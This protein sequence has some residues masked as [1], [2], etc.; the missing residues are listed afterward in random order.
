[1][2]QSRCQLDEACEELIRDRHF[3]S[4]LFRKLASV[5]PEG[6]RELGDAVARYVRRVAS[7]AG[8]PTQDWEDLA[9]EVCAR[10]AS[11]VGSFRSARSGDHLYRWVR[12]IVRNQ[13]ADYFRARARRPEGEPVGGPQ[14]ALVQVADA[15]G[16]DGKD[17]AETD[18]RR[19]ALQTAVKIV[20]GLV[21]ARTWQAFCAVA[22]QRRD[23]AEVAREF[24]MT[25]HAVHQ[26]VYRVRRQLTYYGQR[27]AA[28][29][30]DS[31]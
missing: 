23:A 1:V 25:S 19:I 28:L 24:G 21:G 14:P 22:F 13:M 8:I 16:V 30:N 4:S 3:T 6:W 17:V 27:V 31:T 5:S 15:G 11:H 26:A 18:E 9:Q 20:R 12:A 29:R 2:E 10:V 7:Q